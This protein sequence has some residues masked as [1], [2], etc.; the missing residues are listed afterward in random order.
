MQSQEPSPKPKS[1][2]IENVSVGCLTVFLSVALAGGAYSA[3]YRVT[4]D[5]FL[6]DLLLYGSP[7]LLFASVVISFF[8]DKSLR[9]RRLIRFMLLAYVVWMIAINL[10]SAIA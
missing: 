5:G 6:F 1:H 10:W 9:F 4:S 3:I 8:Y 2:P 7:F